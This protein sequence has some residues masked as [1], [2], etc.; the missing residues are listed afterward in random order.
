MNWQP[1]EVGELTAMIEA[2]LSDVDVSHA[3]ERSVQ[4]VRNQRRSLCIGTPRG[5][6]PRTR[7]ARG[8]YV[9]GVNT[10]VHNNSR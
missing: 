6:G 3:L 1:A 4:S 5:P 2:G 9:E 8:R 7:G 10:S